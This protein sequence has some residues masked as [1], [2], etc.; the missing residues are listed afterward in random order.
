MLTN[1]INPGIYLEER[2]PVDEALGCM[3]PAAIT[4]A[5]V[6]SIIGFLISGLI[7]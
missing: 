6:G 1:T 4:I 2:H 3:V 5:L 7:L